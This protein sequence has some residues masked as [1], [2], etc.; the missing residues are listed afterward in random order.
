MCNN[1]ISNSSTNKNLSYAA[2]LKQQT[3][4]AIADTATSGNYG[5][6]E[7][8]NAGILLPHEPIEVTY[9][10]EI[11]MKLVSTILLP[12]LQQL[13][14]SARKLSMFSEMKTILLSIPTIVNADCEVHLGLKFIKIY[15][16][17]KL[18]LTGD[19]DEVS[20]MWTKDLVVLTTTTT[21]SSTTT[22]TTNLEK[23]VAQSVY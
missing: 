5:P 18:I 1:I 22:T 21:T 19:C 2:V 12:I 3:I 15:K 16:D 14:K 4:K 6:V 8:A 11:N 23:L 17:S 9:A 10:N 20:R 13:P 7:T